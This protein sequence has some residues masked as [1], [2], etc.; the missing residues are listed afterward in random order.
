MLLAQCG[1]AGGLLA[2]AFCDPR[3]DLWW[4]VVFALIV[5]FSSATQD[6]AL[7]ALRIESTDASLQ[8]A[9]AATYQLGYRIAVLA[10]GTCLALLSGA[11]SP[12]ALAQAYQPPRT[13]DGRPDLQGF[14]SS[15][16]MT[17]LERPDGITDLVVPRDKA[18]EVL[19]LK[20]SAPP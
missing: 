20:F 2:M 16:F 11:W 1:I 15:H 13:P 5:A 17:P 3:T 4:M 19:A 9:T 14:W 12:A 10:A 6:I 8:G 18:A 7:D